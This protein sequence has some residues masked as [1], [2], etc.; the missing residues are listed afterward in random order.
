[1]NVYTYIIDNN[2]YINLTN[3]CSNNC[4]FCIRNTND[5]ISGYKLWLDQDPT[6]E[7]V[8]GELN[9]LN[10]SDYEQLVFCGFGEPMYA[11]D[12]IKT[13]AD[14]AHSNGLTTRINTN[15][16]SKLILGRDVTQELGRYIDIVN[17]SLNATD[18]DKYDGI[19][20]S[21]YGK[22]AF[23]AMIEFAKGCA[24]S[25]KQVIL[26]VVDSIGADEIAKSRV[27]ADSIGVTLRV[28]E[29]ID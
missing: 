25:C 4:D 20:H 1:M 6:A 17:V 26:S 24:N 12:V 21:E 9:K 5:G 2:I 28:R 11:Y 3:R 23:E 7:Q 15:G 27:I 13:V 8:I 22:G 16:Q 14:Y 18:R 10:L 19:C 29:L